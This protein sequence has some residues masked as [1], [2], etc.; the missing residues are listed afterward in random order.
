MINA[1]LLVSSQSE[2]LGKWVVAKPEKDMLCRRIRDA[3]QVI[4]GRAVAVNFTEKIDVKE[5]LTYKIN[6]ISRLFEMY[7]LDN[8]FCTEQQISI[9]EK[10]I[11]RLKSTTKFDIIERK[12]YYIINIDV[13][14]FE[15]YDN[16]DLLIFTNGEQSNEDEFEDIFIN[17]RF[18]F[19]CDR[20]NV[21]MKEIND[22]R[23][24]LIDGKDKD[25]SV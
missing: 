14:K 4:L 5:V 2:I 19:I 10:R 11:D 15:L 7:E 25:E 13:Y 16:G 9:L 20:V 18:N 8:I 24:I 22:T 21:T 6:E 3:F 17:S 12:D 1:D 23:N